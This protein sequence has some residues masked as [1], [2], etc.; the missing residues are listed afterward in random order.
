MVTSKPAGGCTSVFGR[1]SGGRFAGLV[2]RRGSKPWRF[3]RLGAVGRGLAHR[4]TSPKIDRRRQPCSRRQRSANLLVPMGLCAAVHP[5]QGHRFTLPGHRAG[6]GL[7]IVSSPNR[8][9][10]DPPGLWI[11]PVGVSYGRNSCEKDRIG[12]A[13]LRTPHNIPL[14]P[15]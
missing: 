8:R 7:A 3:L 9:L 12:K 10:H 6:R 2:G 14:V 11:E 13:V 5:A 15:S 1:D 4:T